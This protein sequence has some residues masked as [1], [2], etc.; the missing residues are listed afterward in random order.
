MEYLDLV[1]KYWQMNEEFPQTSSVTV[2]YLF[3]LERW[4][5]GQ[6]KDFELSDAELVKSLRLNRSTIKEGKKIL[7]DLGLIS[8]QITK[9]FPTFYKIIPDYAIRK[10][11]EV[12]S[13]APAV[14]KEKP[15]AKPL[16]AEEKQIES[17]APPPLPP[18]LLA[19][20][21]P[22][23]AVK[24]APSVPVEEAFTSQ[25]KPAAKSS[26]PTFPP[27][28]SVIAT[29]KTVVPP[30]EQPDEAPKKSNINIPSLEEFMA[31][32]KT[33]STYEEGLDEHLKIKYEY[34]KN[35]GWI[36]GVNRPIVNWKQ[37]LKNTMP[38]LKSNNQNIFNIP[39]I[40]KINRPKATYNE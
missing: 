33:L 32:A 20:E 35:N 36:S 1:K 15:V 38:Y 34:W 37:T 22:I 4:A 16:I 28:E 40:P 2:I 21:S 27:Q 6:R 29:P 23:A 17:V 8:Y 12:I 9:G 10:G 7:R 3:I 14:E 25:A 30:Q 24:E 31:F 11:K 5:C 18:E 39:N 26:L 19:I 13:A